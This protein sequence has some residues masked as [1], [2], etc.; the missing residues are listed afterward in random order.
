[1]EAMQHRQHE[2]FVNT[3]VLGDVDYLAARIVTVFDTTG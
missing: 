1:M 3:K 2:S